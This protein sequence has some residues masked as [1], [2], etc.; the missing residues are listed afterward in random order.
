MPLD[1]NVAAAKFAELG[2]NDARAFC[3]GDA[4]VGFH[5]LRVLLAII[6]MINFSTFSIAS[7]AGADAAKVYADYEEHVIGAGKA[8]LAVHGHAAAVVVKAVALAALAGNTDASQWWYAVLWLG[9]LVLSCAP[10]RRGC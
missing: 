2:P 1:E 3:A 9:H 10:C 6:P 4:T 5:A 8:H 7:I